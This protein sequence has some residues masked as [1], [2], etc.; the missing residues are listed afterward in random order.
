MVL[1][2][3]MAP[4]LEPPG[5]GFP[6]SVATK[7]EVIEYTLPAASVN[8]PSPGVIRTGEGGGVGVPPEYSP[9]CGA[10]SVRMTMD[11]AATWTLARLGLVIVVPLGLVLLITISLRPVVGSPSWLRSTV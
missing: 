1:A 6:F 9:T 7:P 8:D 3:S 5:I 11:P 4:V 10:S 2:S